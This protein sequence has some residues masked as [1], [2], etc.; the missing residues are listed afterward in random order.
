MRIVYFVQYFNLPHEP[1]GS[2]AH[3]LAKTWAAAGHRVSVV[4]GAVNHKTLTVPEHLRGR[5]VTVERLAENLR[6]VRVWSYAGIRGS[7]R[8]RVLNFLSYAAVAGTLGVLRAGR[9]DVVYASSTPLTVG[10]PGMFAATVRRCP[11]L[12][13]VR[14]LWPESAVVAGV[15]DRRALLTRAAQ[16]ASERFYRS[17]GRVVGVT[18]G[19]V[20]G[21]AGQGVPR[22]KLLFAPNGVDDWMLEEPFAAPSRPGGRLR[23]VYCGAHGMWNGLDQIL[24][25]A[26][27]LRD[28]PVDLELVGDGDRKG[29]LVRRAREEGLDNVTFRDAM[30]KRDAFDALRAGTATVI[31]SPDDPFHRMV[32]AN[33]VFDYLAAGRPLVA[34]MAGETADLV[35]RAG[36]GVVSPPE[37]PAELAEAIRRLV[38]TPDDE[39]ARMGRA[40]RD[41]VADR[42]SRRDTALRLLGAMEELAGRGSWSD[43]HPRT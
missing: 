6:V 16:A 23:V 5:P 22:S 38:R 26:H 13:E 2:R 31:V 36:C 9:P 3:Q 8:K 20:E 34:G 37:R 40:G 14:D 18:E 29:H 33:K 7:F 25:A 39:L 4:T 11:W 42:Y 21:L 1:G 35:A 19:I 15:L 30:P 28:D 41:H 10:L 12:F 43:S 17:A 27:L 32:L 24:D